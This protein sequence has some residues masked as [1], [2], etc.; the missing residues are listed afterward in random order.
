[1]PNSPSTSASDSHLAPILSL[2]DA[3]SE[4]C[5][6]SMNSARRVQAYFLHQTSRKW[7]SG[8]G[9]LV[10]FLVVKIATDRSV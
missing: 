8:G 3:V 2:R 7:A 10:R 9:N 6:D 1:M 4:G 5:D